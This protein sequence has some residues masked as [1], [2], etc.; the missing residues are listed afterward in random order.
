[1]WETSLSALMWETSLIYRI[2]HATSQ[3][4]GRMP[5]GVC[6]GPMS[7][8]FSL[9]DVCSQRNTRARHTYKLPS[10]YCEN[11]PFQSGNHVVGVRY[12]AMLHMW[13]P[14]AQERFFARGYVLRVYA[15]TVYHGQ[16]QSILDCTKPFERVWSGD[17]ANYAHAHLTHCKEG[18]V[19]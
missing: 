9:A 14:G 12:P 3:G 18:R 6:R 13:F 17:W 7:E 8:S 10:P 5:K 2:E 16:K 4:F 11:L 19:A 15:G 1:M